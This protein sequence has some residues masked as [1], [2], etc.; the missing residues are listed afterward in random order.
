ME[1]GYLK[2]ARRLAGKSYR[3]MADEC[4]R[5]HTFFRRLELG[6]EAVLTEEMRTRIAAA[7]GIP[8]AILFP[9]QEAAE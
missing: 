9:D 4:G 6:R 1:R 5:T 2:A 3:D 8:E 7:L